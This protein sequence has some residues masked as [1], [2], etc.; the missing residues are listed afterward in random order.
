VTVRHELRTAPPARRALAERMPFDVSAAAAEFITGPSRK[1]RGGWA[2]RSARSWP[3]SRDPP[4]PR[5]ANSV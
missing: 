2:S 3:A 1:I 4:G 5:L